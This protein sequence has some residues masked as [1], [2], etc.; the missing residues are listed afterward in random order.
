MRPK[1]TRVR[2]PRPLPAVSSLIIWAFK[3][4]LLKHQQQCD[5]CHTKKIRCDREIA[6]ANC[7]AAQRECHRHRRRKFGHRR[8]QQQQQQQQEPRETIVASEEEHRSPTR[9]LMERHWSKSV[10]GR[11]DDSSGQFQTRLSD[12]GSPT[13]IVGSMSTTSSAD[14][15]AVPDVEDIPWLNESGSE[16]VNLS[17]GHDPNVEQVQTSEL[18]NSIQSVNGSCPV[19]NQDLAPRDKMFADMDLQRYLGPSKGIIESTIDLG[20]SNL[21]MLALNLA[22]RMPASQWKGKEKR[23]CSFSAFYQSSMYPSP[24]IILLILTCTS[25]N[26][27]T[28]LLLLQ[29]QI[30][31]SD[32]TKTQGS[33]YY[34]GI[35]L[36]GS[37][38]SFEQMT[39]ALLECKVHG[40][41][42]IQFIICVNFTAYNFLTALESEDISSYFKSLICGS[43][44]KYQKTIIEALN[45][46]EMKP[47]PDPCLLQS[48]LSAAMTMQEMGYMQRCWQLNTIACR[49]CALLSGPS[50]TD[51]Q[52]HLSK[53]DIFYMRI[54]MMKCF[55]FDRALSAN[56][57]QP[58]SLANIDLDISL[59]KTEQPDHAMLLTMVEIAQIQ[60]SI[61]RETT[62]M[63]HSGQAE[64]INTGKIRSQASRLRQVM[65]KAEKFRNSEAV[66][67][68][69][70]LHFEWTGV[71]FM[72][73]SMMT[74]ISRLASNGE[75]QTHEECLKHSRSCLSILKS[76]LDLASQLPEHGAKCSCSL[77]WLIPLFTLRPIF[78]LFRNVV[79]TFD[80]L[81]LRLIQD[82]AERLKGMSKT[83]LSILTIE[84]LCNS[85]LNIYSNFAENL[86]YSRHSRT[87]IMDTP[88]DMDMASSEPLESLAD[89]LSNSD[90]LAPQHSNQISVNI[91]GNSE[92]TTMLHG[93]NNYSLMEEQMVNV[94]TFAEFTDGATALGLGIDPSLC[95]E[96][97]I[98]DWLCI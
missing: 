42:L 56:V 57:N 35:N 84:R 13:G 20:K 10:T 71:E 17:T 62:V 32:S 28:A 55:V 21:L 78:F 70:Y 68:D 12:T 34:V 36:N 85:L 5:Y 18:D 19:A 26:I 58:A 98:P 14:I 97:E 63:N 25:P 80:A 76:L 72:Y 48:L 52:H 53:Q 16:V 40:Q 54:N 49:V 11:H 30:F 86:I 38:E 61:I 65:R 50:N 74:S 31:A 88:R 4:Y 59:L 83:L 94:D 79:A 23:P 92:Q 47:R 45:H 91:P 27:V 33:S 75:Q 64:E 43:K 66:L 7:I 82:V 67:Q 90:D 3:S 87:Q 9:P 39:H 60:D 81:D 93:L 96:L 24:E 89:T 2:L 37:L 69:P 73:F 8:Q 95:V 22:K 29:Q 77:A 1:S 51:L 6:C 41:K 15:E 46:L 44:K